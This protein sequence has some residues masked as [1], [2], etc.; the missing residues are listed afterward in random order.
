MIEKCK[1][2]LS[3]RS[4]HWILGGEAKRKIQFFSLEFQIW[5]ESWWHARRTRPIS[6]RRCCHTLRE[7]LDLWMGRV[8][9]RLSIE[10]FRFGVSRHRVWSLT[11]FRFRLSSNNLHSKRRGVT[12]HLSRRAQTCVR[13]YFHA[14]SLSQ[15]LSYHRKSVLDP[16]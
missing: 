11:L 6:Q 12:D 3:T 10:V 16:F 5:E 1:V 2:D 8:R 9:W 13:G 4:L 14:P 15:V 7:Q